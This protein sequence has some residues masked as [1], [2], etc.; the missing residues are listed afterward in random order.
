MTE[1]TKSP[2]V[3][4]WE[5]K[6][7]ELLNDDQLCAHL[8]DILGKGRPLSKR[9]LARWDALREGPPITRIGRCKVRR[10]GSTRAWLKARESDQVA[11]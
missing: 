9:T 8:G 5:L 4:F 7:D 10:V 3:P 11:A 2:L 1:Q 6:D